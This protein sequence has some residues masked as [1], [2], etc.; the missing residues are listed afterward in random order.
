MRTARPLT[1]KRVLNIPLIAVMLYAVIVGVIMWTSYSGARQMGYNW[2][3]YQVPKYIYTFTDDGFQA[4]EILTGLWATIVLSLICFVLATILG[5]GVALLRLSGLIVGKAVA[6]GYLEF[7][8]NIPLLVLLYLFY[9]VL[10]PIFG[11]DRW[12][13]AVLTL[14]VYHSALISEIFRAGINSV[15]VGQWEAAAS[16]GM[17]RAQAYRYII[18]PQSVRIMLPP[19]TGEIVNLIKSSAIVSVIAVAELTT[20]GRN[21]ISDTYM[22]FEIWFTIAAAYLALTLVLSFGVSALERRFTTE[23]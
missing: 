21:I 4:G 16:I 6:I 3:W 12:T 11:L 17:S 20:V 5:L 18:L 7:V 8:R 13:A 9:Y 22:S 23:T 2:Q 19:L 15:A 14:G 1:L 10:G